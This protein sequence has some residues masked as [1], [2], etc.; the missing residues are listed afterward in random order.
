MIPAHV[1]I[2]EDRQLLIVAVPYYPAFIQDLRM[3]GLRGNFIK[4]RKHYEFSLALLPDVVA[5]LN[6]HFPKVEQ[7]PSVALASLLSHL[8]EED[9]MSVYRVLAK[10]YKTGLMRELLTKTFGP[11][12]HIEREIVASRPRRRIEIDDPESPTAEEMIGDPSTAFAE[13]VRDL[14]ER[15]QVTVPRNDARDRIRRDIE[16]ERPRQEE[17][18]RRSQAP[19]PPEEEEIDPERRRMHR[20]WDHLADVPRRR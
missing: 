8:D 6:R 17:A 3:Q 2:D 13:V 9:L 11:F 15:G 20:L 4:E 16:R 12:I 18:R 5:C 1:E 7:T 14:S 19:A 10:K